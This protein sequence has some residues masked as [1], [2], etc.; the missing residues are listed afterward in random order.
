MDLWVFVVA[1]A[2][3]RH[4]VVVDSCVCDVEVSPP[5]SRESLNLSFDDCYG[6][7]CLVTSSHSDLV[8]SGRLA[9]TCFHL[10]RSQRLGQIFGQLATVVLVLVCV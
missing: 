5:Q 9:Q 10:A 8:D 2:V 3:V 6:G 1:V 4:F 7:C